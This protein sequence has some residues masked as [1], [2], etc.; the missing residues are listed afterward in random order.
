M[1]K[2]RHIKNN[3]NDYNNYCQQRTEVKSILRSV[4]TQRQSSNKGVLP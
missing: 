4:L 1:K 3:F 2:E